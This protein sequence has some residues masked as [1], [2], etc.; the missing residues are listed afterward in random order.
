MAKTHATTTATPSLIKIT[1]SDGSL[2]KADVT[3][4][5]GESLGVLKALSYDTDAGG[6]ITRLEITIALGEAKPEPKAEDAEATTEP[7]APVEG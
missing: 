1:S 7:V 4:H 5:A 2:A 6:T 3:D